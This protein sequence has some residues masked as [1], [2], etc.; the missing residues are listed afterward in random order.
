MNPPLFLEE[1][2]D[3]WLLPSSGPP[4]K[5]PDST[6]G[7]LPTNTQ[8]RIRVL[9]VEDNSVDSR[10]VRLTLE[11]VVGN[12]YEVVTEATVT[13]AVERLA[14]EEFQI[15]LLDLDL[16][17]SSGLDTFRRIRDH[18]V[19]I[20]IVVLTGNADEELAIQAI[21]QGAQEYVLKGGNAATLTR[22]IRYAMSRHRMRRKLEQALEISRAGA[23]N[24]HVIIE[25]NVDG[26]VVVNQ[27]GLIV[28]ANS[29]TEKF[30]A[31]PAGTLV[32]QHF[33]LKLVPGSAREADIVNGLSLVVPTEIR[34]C[35]I[36]WDS[37]PAYW[38]RLR[39]LTERRQAESH[40]HKLE[41]AREVQQGLLP[42]S[43]PSLNG[44][45]MAGASV[46]A[47]ETGGDY[48]DYLPMPDGA[49]GLA[50]ADASGHGIAAAMLITVVS[51]YLRAFSSLSCDPGEVLRLV[52]QT[53]APQIA[54]G[55]FVTAVLACV[56]P[57]RHTVTYASAGHP[58]A[59]LIDA[60]GKVRLD[61]TSLDLPI[62]LD[63]DCKFQSG[64][65]S[66]LQPGDTFVLMSDGILEAMPP[67]GTL[68]GKDRVIELIHKHREESSQKIVKRLLSAV[69]DHC[70]PGAPADDLTVLI[71]KI[72]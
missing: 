66:S 3:Q 5:P 13:K 11:H 14:D 27:K 61:L 45:D 55:N 8:R 49:L 52:A 19:D 71:A 63:P 57:V 16:P 32:G 72:A 53:L 35:A 62:G 34:C 10:L 39:D 58:S 33:P 23:A 28:H 69:Q 42:K 26:I 41:L 7:D 24:L 31:D 25:A 21:H 20:P 9:L 60:T 30:F 47:D 36:V 18:A 65:E 50:V 29:A 48:F 46:T 17:D 68:F 64:V 22:T 51:S 56:D 38:V 59:L 67:D 44:F 1:D 43:A 54:E 37:Q 4:R 2:S 15:V 40:R 70:S 12:T 6:G